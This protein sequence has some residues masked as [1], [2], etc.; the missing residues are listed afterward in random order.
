MK[1]S[2]VKTTTLTI[3]PQVLTFLLRT[4]AADENI[5][6]IEDEITMFT[7]LSN[8]TPSQYAE[9]MAAKEL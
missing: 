8:K 3:Y 1:P 5:L 7:Q 2:I 9:M 4:Y 6:D